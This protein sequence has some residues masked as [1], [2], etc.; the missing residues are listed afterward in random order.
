MILYKCINLRGAEQDKPYNRAIMN[1]GMKGILERDGSEQFKTLFGYLR[2]RTDDLL[3]SFNFRMCPV[4][5][6]L[7]LMIS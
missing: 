2:D 1:K 4:K 5:I 7:E 3:P 6:N